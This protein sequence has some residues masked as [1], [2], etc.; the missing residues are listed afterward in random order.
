MLCL[1]SLGRFRSNM[2][3]QKRAGADC[4]CRAGGA[5]WKFFLPSP[6]ESRNKYQGEAAVLM[7][8]RAPFGRPLQRLRY[9]M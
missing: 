5:L 3:L 1:R 8:E 2:G 6:L 7:G 9:Y 4:D